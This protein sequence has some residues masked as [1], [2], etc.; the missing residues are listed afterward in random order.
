[1]THLQTELKQ[2]KEA[3]S[4]MM[5]LVKSQLEKSKEAFINFDTELAE[6][7]IHHEKRINAMELSI[8]RDCENIFALFNPVATDLRFVISI[9]KI[10]SDLERIADHAKGVANYVLEL[11]KPADASIIEL[12]KMIKMFDIAIT[13]VED[14]A[15]A[16][17]TEDTKLARKVYKKDST[18]NKINKNSS[19]IIR[20]FVKEKPDEMRSALFLFSTIRKVE[21]VGDHVKNIAENIIFHIDAKVL[22][23]KKKKK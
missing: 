15:T 21:R 23:H 22:K 9:L 1:M 17:D 16:F 10:N 20:E 8:D 12:V 7:I 13:M 19:K 14:I 3:T 4:E 6:E 18:I 2:L 5:D 11:E